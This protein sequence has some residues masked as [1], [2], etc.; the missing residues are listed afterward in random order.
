MLSCRVM[1]LIYYHFTTTLVNMYC[2][3][4]KM[5]HL[6]FWKQVAA[7]RP[8]AELLEPGSTGAHGAM[9]RLQQHPVSVPFAA[10]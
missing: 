8:A 4:K 1:L 10:S 6:S 5:F 9:P 7:Q 3:M 2:W